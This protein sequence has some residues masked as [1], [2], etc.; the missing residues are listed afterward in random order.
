MT[1][2]LPTFNNLPIHNVVYNTEAEAMG[3]AN[4]EEFVVFAVL[5]FEECDNGYSFAMMSREV[6]VVARNEAE[7]LH[8]VNEAGFVAD[9]AQEV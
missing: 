1:N 9:E 5:A 4:Y 2:A 7:A 3:F 8:I 6:F